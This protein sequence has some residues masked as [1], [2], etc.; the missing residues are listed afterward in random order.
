MK[1]TKKISESQLKTLVMESVKR[2]LMEQKET[3]MVNQL[4]NDWKQY[5]T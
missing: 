2:V 3:A 1:Q 4:I 5:G